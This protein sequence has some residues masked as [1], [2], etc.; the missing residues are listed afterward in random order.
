ME[1]ARQLIEEIRHDLRP[2]AERL[3]THPYVQA[4]AEGRIARQR[5]RLFAGEQYHITGSDLRSL[6]LLAARYGGSPSGDFFLGA[7]KGEEEARRALLAFSA[8]LGLTEGELA[9]YEPRPDAQAYAAYVAWLALYA[10]DA[11]VAAAFLVN[12]PAWGANCGR[13]ARALKEKYGL[14]ET[15]L[16]FFQM[17][18]EPSA[19]FEEAALAIVAHGLQRGVAAGEVRRAARLLQAYELM[20]WDAVYKASLPD[21][22]P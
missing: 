1:A 6:A 3:Q 19:E 2:V 14:V 21:L 7:L 17:F 9:A 20:F 16:A 8:A 10:A 22:S 15:A 11:A 18:A 4:L 12:F 5:L 13:M